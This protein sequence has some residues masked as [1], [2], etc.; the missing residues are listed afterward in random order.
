MNYF[1]SKK[2]IFLIGLVLISLL[3]IFFFRLGF[4]GYSVYENPIDF[5]EL[6]DSFEI[7]KGQNFILD[8]DIY[9]DYVFSDDSSLFDI[10]KEGLINF[11][12]ESVGEFD[13][14]IIALK[15]VDDFKF[16]LV[17]FRVVE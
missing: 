9:G 2:F 15:T 5:E 6:P 10:S 11:V 17:K 14:V 16:K 1:S 12:P 3:A 7:I 13:V 4:T 8:L